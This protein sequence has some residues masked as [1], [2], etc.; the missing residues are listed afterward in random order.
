MPF[1]RVV[2]TEYLVEFGLYETVE[3]Q[4]L[5]ELAEL[6]LAHCCLLFAFTIFMPTASMPFTGRPGVTVMQ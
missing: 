2:A 1:E 3:S 4:V 6:V 5:A